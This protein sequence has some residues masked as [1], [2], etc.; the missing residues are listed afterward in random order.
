MELA[1]DGKVEIPLPED[2]FDPLVSLCGIL[3]HRGEEFAPVQT[4]TESSLL[5][6]AALVNKYNYYESVDLWAK[7]CLVRN[8]FI[9]KQFKDGYI[10]VEDTVAAL[11]DWIYIS[12]IFRRERDMM[13]LVR[14]LLLQ[15][16]ESSSTDESF[17][18]LPPALS[19]ESL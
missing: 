16:T 7:Y 12:K 13:I 1:R 8:P 6:L 3:H 14:R 18:R 2:D 9:R 17:G 11:S 4:V 15:A 5:Q 10:H 19:G